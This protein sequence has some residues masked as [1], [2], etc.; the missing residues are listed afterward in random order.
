MASRLNPYLSFDDKARQALEFYASVF[1]GTLRLST[2]GESGMQPAPGDADKVMHG[3]LESPAGFTMMASDTP[4]GM[5]RTSGSSIS[6]SLSG[7]D[8][9]ELR[10][11]WEKLT[12][13]GAV[14]MPLQKQ[15]WGDEFGMCEDA[16]GVA[17]MVDIVQPQ[18]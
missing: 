10:G 5:Q 17:W 18:A 4:T 3:M 11:Y 9:D 15:V 7:E 12:E 6:I 13:G 8:G 14:T 2:F 16:F 1:G